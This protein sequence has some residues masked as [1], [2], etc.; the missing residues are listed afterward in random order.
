MAY[1]KFIFP[2]KAFGGY[3]P[4]FEG[5]FKFNKKHGKGKFH[6]AQDIWIEGEWF[7]D[8]LE[9]KAVVYHL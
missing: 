3:A 2:R 1:G 4:Y 7:N 8:F 9:G 6:L 5:K